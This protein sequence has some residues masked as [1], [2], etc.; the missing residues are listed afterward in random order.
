MDLSSTQ[1]EI[2]NAESKKV[3]I[4][5]PHFNDSL[6]LTLLKNC[7][8]ELLE[9]GVKEE[10]IEILRCPGA[11]ELPY[12]AQSTIK[13]SQP[14]VLIALGII[15]EGET[16]HY[17]HVAQTTH[18]GLMKVQLKKKTP[19]IIGV[20]TCKDEKQAIERVE[21]EGLNKGKEFAKAAL[22]V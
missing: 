18:Q 11:L 17:A 1:F 8:Q 7:K 14:D 15:V 4:L 20:L 12:L 21:S 13:T 16:D 6:G 19:I 2:E 10:N 9:Q 3:A 5:L 22:F